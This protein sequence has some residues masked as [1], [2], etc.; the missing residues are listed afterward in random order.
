MSAISESIFHEKIDTTKP[1][2]LQKMPSALNDIYGGTNKLV[3]LDGIEVNKSKLS[4]INNPNEI[5]RYEIAFLNPQQATKKYGDKGKYGAIEITKGKIVAKKKGTDS[6]NVSFG[7][8][9]ETPENSKPLYVLNGRLM[10]KDFDFSKI[11]TDDIASINILKDAK[12]IAKYNNE[13][14]NGVIEITTKQ[15]VNTSYNGYQDF[16]ERNKDVKSC[17]WKYNPQLTIIIQLKNGIAETYDLSN[18]LN[19]QKAIKKYG[20]LPIAPPPP[21]PLSAKPKVTTLPG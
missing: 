4:H 5:N 2:P 1:P 16:L 15:N 10:P 13:G 17:S 9:S 12:A 8:E 7:S 20:T 6:S 14:K 19:E 11:S 3:L 18:E 21:P